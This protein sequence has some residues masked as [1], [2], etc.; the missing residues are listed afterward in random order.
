LVVACYS[1]V[2][3]AGTDNFNKNR[4]DYPQ[5]KFEDY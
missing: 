4:G 3:Q 5:G 2:N 1:S